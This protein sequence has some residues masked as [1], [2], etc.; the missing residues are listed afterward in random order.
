MRCL[1]VLLPLCDARDNRVRERALASAHSVIQK[2]D[3][4]DILER[5]EERL[6]DEFESVD[7]RRGAVK[8]L[9]QLGEPT[10]D[11]LL[12]ALHDEDHQVRISAIDALGEMKV[13]E[14]VEPIIAAMRDKN[15][16]VRWH[17]AA[18]LSKIGS[19]KAVPR[20]VVALREDR[21]WW[22]RY[23]AAEALGEIGAAEAIK[24]LL[25]ALRD[26]NEDE[27]VKRKAQEAVRKIR[28]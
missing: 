27:R 8:I 10:T 2:F 18:A 23:Y 24:P 20:L 4:S 11:L 28:N 21:S 12:T 14:A 1:D 3:I 15:D 6:D 17:C 7:M 13:T 16:W 5:L 25:S 19:E 22:V 9:A 26:E